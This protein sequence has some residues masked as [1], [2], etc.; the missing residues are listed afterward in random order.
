LTAIAEKESDADRRQG[1]K[2]AIDNQFNPRT[3]DMTLGQYAGVLNSENGIQVTERNGKLIPLIRMD[4]SQT[5][6]LLGDYPYRHL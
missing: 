6:A 3:V 4:I 1:F 5:Q 2:N